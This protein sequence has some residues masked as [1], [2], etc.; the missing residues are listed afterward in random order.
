MRLGRAEF[1]IDIEARHA[2]D[3]RFL[4]LAI[5]DEIG[6]RDLLEV[7]LFGKGGDLRAAHDRAVVIDQFAD[8]ADRRQAGELAEIDGG[9]GVAGAHE[10]A[11]FARHQRENMAGANEIGSGS[12]GLARLRTVSVRSSAEMP[13]V[14]PCLKSTRR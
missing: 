14:V 1:G 8:H 7:M 5:G 10:H 6:D 13:V 4:A 11:A 3:Q 12:V 2:L 9:F